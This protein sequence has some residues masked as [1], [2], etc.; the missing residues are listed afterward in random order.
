M[1]THRRRILEFLLR[2]GPALL[3]L[4]VIFAVSADSDPYSVL[5]SHW[6]STCLSFHLGSFCEDEML[7]RFSHVTEYAFLAVLIFRG[8]FWGRRWAP[9]GLVMGAVAAYAFALLDEIHQL[10]VPERTFQLSDLGL[11]GLGILIG[12]SVFILARLSRKKTQ[13]PRVN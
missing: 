11:D 6:E 2:W 3:W 9:G 1:P 4:G 13:P 8:I 7:G 12:M 5:P 10:F